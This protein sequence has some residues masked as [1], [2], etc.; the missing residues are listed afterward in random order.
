MKQVRFEESEVP[1]QTLARFGLTQEKIEDLPMWAL[2]DIGQG[3]RSPL[4]P[5]QVNNHKMGNR[6]YVSVSAQQLHHFQH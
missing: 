6:P 5:I 2:E 1:Y 4:L 3:R